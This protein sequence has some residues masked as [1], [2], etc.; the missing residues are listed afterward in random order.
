MK[1][2]SVIIFALLLVGCASRPPSAALTAEEARSVALRLANDQAFAVYQ[3]RPFRDGQPAKFV[4]SHWVW[5]GREG[6]G[7]GDIQATVA[8]AADGSTNHVELQ[9][10]DSQNEFLLRRQF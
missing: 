10:F 3:C 5:A 1:I 6:Y 9:L 2:S 7:H 4:A 8:L